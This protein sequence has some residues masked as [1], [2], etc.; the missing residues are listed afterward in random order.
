MRSVVIVHDSANQRPWVAV[1]RQ[2]GSELLRLQNRDQLDKVCARLG[3]DIAAV[4]TQG[5][6]TTAA[7]L[8]RAV[9]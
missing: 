7:D 4:K 8:R 2:S 6:T 5:R 9:R 1:D 3:W